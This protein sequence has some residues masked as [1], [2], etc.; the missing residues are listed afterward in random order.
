MNIFGAFIDFFGGGFGR[1]MC[2]IRCSDLSETAWKHFLLEPWKNCDFQHVALFQF[3]V[4]EAYENYVF[5][6][7]STI[8]CKKHNGIQQL[9]HH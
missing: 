8:V 3:V 7:I 5:T 9:Q 2:K 4:L 1:K 6:N